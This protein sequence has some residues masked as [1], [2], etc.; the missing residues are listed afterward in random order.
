VLNLPQGYWAVF[1]AVLVVQGSVGGSWKAAVDRLVGTVLGA[2]YGGA[3]ATFVP[4]NDPVTLGVALALSLTPLALVAA[5]KPSYRVAP[6][7]AVVLLLGTTASTEGP[8]LAATL[9]TLEVTLGGVVGMG[10]SLFV[11]PA[12]AH[13][14]MGEAANKVLQRL[15]DLLAAEMRGLLEPVPVQ[16]LIAKHDA[17]RTAQTALETI[18]DEAA[19]E[20][21]N[22]LTDDADPE[23]VART[24]RRV[25]HDLIILGRASAE[26][27][28]EPMHAAL[29]PALAEFSSAA[30]RFLR[31]VGQAFAERR[32][33]PSFELLS[34]ALLNL[35]SG[36]AAKGD[37]SL[38]ALSFGLEQFQQ[39][40][41]DLVLRAAE[42][43]R[44]KPTD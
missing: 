7:T 34:P 10:V 14:L 25:R 15:A 35:L 20:R 30:A 12:R 21:R 26:P 17:V 4:H 6:I 44:Y 5:L 37:A 27:L 42:F 1:T 39:N 24:L 40:L 38:T 13:Q 31:S 18:A 3:V 22:H 8:F 32:P 41:N 43:A 33:P 36:I 2:V 28:P 19:R 23:P 9:R 16:D 11:L 29:G